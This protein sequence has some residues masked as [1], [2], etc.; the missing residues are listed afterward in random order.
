M[1]RRGFLRAAGA[2]GLMG[3]TGAFARFSQT[4][5]ATGLNDY[6]ALVCVFLSGGMDAADTVLPYDMPSY[7]A[8]S[9]IRSGLF[10]RYGVGSGLS[11]RDHNNLL[12]IMPDNSADFGARAFALPPEL[13]PVKSL[14][15]AGNAAIIGNVG[16]LVEPTNR[17]SFADKT[18]QRP[19]RLFSHNDQR[20]NWLALGPEGT[21]HGW[22]GRLADAATGA[23]RASSSKFAAIS[24]GGHN[25][26]VSGETVRPFSAPSNDKLDFDY[27]RRRSYL[28]SGK[29]S[30]MARQ[31]I[32]DQFAN[33]DIAAGNAFAEDMINY[34]GAAVSKIDEY[35]P[36][37]ANAPAFSTAFPNSKLGERLGAVARAISARQQL[38]VNRQ[39]FFV[40]M[41]GFDTHNSQ[42]TKLPALHTELGA[43]LGQFY[44]A[45]EE[46][47]LSNNVT[48]FTGSDFGRTLFD[49]GDGTDHGWGGHHFVMGGAV[50]GNHIYGDMPAM[51]PESDRYTE[52]RGRMIP[53]VS[54]EQYAATLGA[55]FGLS[56]AELD[57]V[58]PN[59]GN[60]D[61]R[62]LGF[63]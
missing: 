38:G 19:A 2:C 49:N 46:L 57:A 63:V 43:A 47:G 39:V 61:T 29:N 25:V 62:N 18:V 6:K 32:K 59:L 42:S 35:G 3:A 30:D 53:S 11:S 7:D 13:A 31:I 60:F 10:G 8:L 48:T 44:A 33:L 16:P 37:I 52:K 55:W 40:R 14:F 36:A 4:A 12:P 9:S 17:K 5:H 22:G 34:N 28:S 1:N 23:D 50:N 45:M 54:V 41:S 20:S 51:D 56:D 21:R 24:I 26:F 15:D 27:M 58:F